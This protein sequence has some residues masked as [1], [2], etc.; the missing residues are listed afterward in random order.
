M[1]TTVFGNYADFEHSQEYL[2]LL[3][4]MEAKVPSVLQNA[5]KGLENNS[6]PWNASA[7]GREDWIGDLDVPK[8]RDKGQAEYLLFVGCAGSF[9]DRNSQV[10]RALCTLLNKAGVDYAVLGTEEG[11]C[12]DPTRRVGHEYLFSMQAPANI[13]TFKRYKVRKVVTACPHCF[14]MIKNEYPDFGLEDVEVI[15]HSQL[16]DDLIAAGRLNP[17][18]GERTT[19]TFHDSCYWG[20]TTTST[21]RR[22]ASWVRCRVCNRWR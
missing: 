11:C 13:E 4:M 16:L 2:N 22:G 9:D 12:G 5:L 19:V 3:T 7:A 20:V 17:K 1:M 21:R 15:H 6:N 14:N 10:L 18:P 8:M